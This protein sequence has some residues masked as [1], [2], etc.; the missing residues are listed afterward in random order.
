MIYIAFLRGINVGGHNKIKMADLKKSLE[1]FGLSR[2][3]TY[4][5]SGNVLFESDKDEATLV[6]ELQ[7][8]INK[9][10]GIALK[11]ILRTAQ[12]ID[13]LI[14]NTPYAGHE[15][16]EGESL[17]VTL[18]GEPLPEEQVRKLK[19]LESSGDQCVV[20]GR[21]VYYLFS[22]SILDSKLADAM[23]KIKLPSTTR[24]WNT[25]N[26]LNNMAKEMQA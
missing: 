21:D 18:L 17:Y 1:E 3:K 7:D 9:S 6:E 22:R 26:K 20:M 2:V 24:N 5:Q 10:F 12:E 25:M 23:N 13:D 11:V 8:E 4:I 14:M 15:L 16:A 19:D